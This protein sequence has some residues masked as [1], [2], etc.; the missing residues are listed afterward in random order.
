MSDLDIFVG[1]APLFTRPNGYLLSQSLPGLREAGVEFRILDYLSPDDHGNRAFLHVD[2]TTLPEPFTRVHQFYAHCVNGRAFTIDRRLYSRIALNR[3]D[4]YSGPVIVKSVLNSRGIP[5]MQFA[6]YRRMLSLQD[7]QTRP[8]LL[9][10]LCPQYRIYDHIGTVPE[11]NWLDPHAMVEK[12]IPGHTRLPVVKYRQEFFFELELTTRTTFNSLLCDPTQVVSVEFPTSAPPEVQAVRHQLNL[13][14]GSVDYFVM[15][16][17]AFV[18]DV[19]KTT[20]V[21]PAWIEA[22]PQLRGYLQA[23][24]ERLVRFAR[25]H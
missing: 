12:F 22:H 6:G 16:G 10:R 13:D 9:D 20:T 19:N 5:E 8:A 11:E 7:A 17:E 18:I 3:H 2:L 23:V 24:T 14:Y 4:D 1:C 21:T 15:D 25:G